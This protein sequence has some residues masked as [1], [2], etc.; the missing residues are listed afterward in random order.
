MVNIGHSNR[1]K[2][3][4]FFEAFPTYFFSTCQPDLLNEIFFVMNAKT[5]CSS[6][7]AGFRGHFLKHKINTLFHI[8]VKIECLSEFL[9]STMFSTFQ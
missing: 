8:I 5:S 9:I 6:I 1:P 7:S 4:P 3:Q 2:V